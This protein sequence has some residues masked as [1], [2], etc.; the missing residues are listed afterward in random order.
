MFSFFHSFLLFSTVIGG[1][2]AEE[3]HLQGRKP[4]DPVGNTKE[5]E[6][7]FQC[8]STD[9]RY[10]RQVEVMRLFGVLVARGLTDGPHL[11]A[12]V[13]RSRQ[14]LDSLRRVL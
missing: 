8:F 13:V 2:Q 5:V 9:I 10:P 6:S 11:D 3:V 14:R 12:V 4:C 7:S 1:G